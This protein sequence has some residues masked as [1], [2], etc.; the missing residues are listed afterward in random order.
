MAVVGPSVAVLVQN[1]SYVVCLMSRRF[2]PEQKRRAT[3]HH[4]GIVS[5]YRTRTSMG[6]RARGLEASGQGPFAPPEDWYEPT[7]REDYRVVI[8]KPGEGYRHVVTEQD[9][10]DRLAQ[11]PPA[12][13]EQLEV[14][15]LS[16][17]TRKKRTFPCYGMQWGNAVYL[18]PIEVELVE[19]FTRPPQPAQRIEARMF[20]GRWQQ[21]GHLWRLVWSER[22]IRD[23]YLNNV[24]I[25]E[26]G[27]LLDERNRSY[28]DRERYAEWFAIRHGYQSSRRQMAGR[29]AQRVTRRHHKK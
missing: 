25:H 27:H 15:Q 2:L 18:Y 22:S 1:A 6:K 29:A 7:D 28:R 21:E 13:L 5:S 11:L 24:L 16:R 14:V 26:L 9:V 23:Y 12:M 8:Q 4:N 20:G 17:M 19:Y 10:R 3:S